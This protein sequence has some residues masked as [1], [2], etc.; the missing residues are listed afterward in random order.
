[1]STCTI[2]RRQFI[3]GAVLAPLASRF[4]AAGV[5]PRRS[6]TEY[7]I[8]FKTG[9][10][11]FHISVTDDG[12]VEDV[13]YYTRDGIFRMKAKPLV[14]ST[15]GDLRGRIWR[16][17]TCEIGPHNADIRF[18]VDGPA[19]VQIDWLMATEQLT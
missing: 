9:S 14:L 6:V 12:E 15:V 3:L 2:E 1:M 11:E 4:A 16:T 19:M 8:G 10:N 18:R 7:V 13:F 17:Y 5:E